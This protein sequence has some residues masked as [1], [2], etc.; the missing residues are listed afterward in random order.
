MIFDKKTIRYYY[1][2]L[3]E[4]I[5]K[6]FKALLLSFF[7]SFLFILLLISLSPLFYR[8]FFINKKEV[9]GILGQYNFDN[10]P[11][12]I[13]E[14]ISSGLV[15]IN[16]GQ[17]V[18][19]L[20]SFWEIKD[21]GRRFRFHLKNDLFWN[22]GKEFSS[23]DID[24][25]F[26]DVVVKV[27]D[28]KTIDFY[29]KEPSAIFPFLLSKPIIRPP[30]VGVA[31]LYRVSRIK[32][33]YDIVKELVLYPNK[34]GLPT[35]VYKFYPSESELV[36]A[37]KLGEV[38][39]IKV[40]KKSLAET[41]KK[42]K[43]TNAQRLIDYSQIMML[44]INHQNEFLKEKEVKKAL[45]MAIAEDFY[46]DFGEMALG[47]I[48]PSSWAYNQSLKQNIYNEETATKIIKKNL[49][50]NASFSLFTSYDHYS[51]ATSLKEYFEKVGLPVKIKIFSYQRPKKFD[52]LLV[53]LKLESDPDQYLLW[54]ST[55]ENAKFLHYKNVKVDKLLEEGRSTLFVEK[56]KK[57]YQEYQKVI[58]D[59][60][61]GLFLYHPY[62]YVIKRK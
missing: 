31:G 29:L 47:P 49:P 26:K 14:K 34:K 60:P 55:Q 27:I 7:L 15:Y 21:E 51:V 19:L 5:K 25:R 43:N 42:W 35:L 52:F 9:I 6:N 50:K 13:T 22:D 30:L 12:E 41:F 4:F 61:P 38:K 16:S 40:Y 46:K 18:P 45:S 62:V 10:L 8:Q 44:L 1:W 24:F 11:Q 17:V 56:R 48:P 37:Y 3:I 33:K 32:K 23:Y 2:F 20:A 57:I 53:S 39:E 36:S 28:K 54:H 59:D 58:T